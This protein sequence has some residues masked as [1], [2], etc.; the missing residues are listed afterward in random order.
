MYRIFFKF[1]N[2]KN[3]KDD[4]VLPKKNHLCHSNSSKDG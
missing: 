1:L 2:D 4:K 3:N